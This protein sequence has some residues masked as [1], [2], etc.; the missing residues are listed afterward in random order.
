M[1]VCELLML[2]VKLLPDIIK[3]V[4]LIIKT[5]KKQTPPP[6]QG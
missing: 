5:I 4:K 2:L 6:E 1:K 3:L